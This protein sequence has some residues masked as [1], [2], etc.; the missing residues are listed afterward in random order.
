M[1]NLIR[2][3]LRRFFFLVFESQNFM[4]L[5]FRMLLMLLC[6]CCGAP[7]LGSRCGGVSDSV[8]RVG[9]SAAAA[10]PPAAAAPPA[11]VNCC[12]GLGVSTRCFDSVCRLGVSTRCVDSA[13]KMCKNVE[14]FFVVDSVC[15]LCE[16]KGVGFFQFCCRLGEKKGCIKIEKN[17]QKHRL[18]TKPD[19]IC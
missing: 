5:L 6:V 13:I 2:W 1:C 15:R 19:K 16:K 3:T 12:C 7:R 14:S 4:L 10:P 17:V 9:V 18:S 8:Y 11:A